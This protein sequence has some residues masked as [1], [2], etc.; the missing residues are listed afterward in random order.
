MTLH[1]ILFFV[2]LFFVDIAA[3][4]QL[5]KGTLEN[6][7]SMNSPFNLREKQKVSRVALFSNHYG[8]LL[9]PRFEKSLNLQVSFLVGLLGV[10]TW[11]HQNS[12]YFHEVLQHIKTFI[13]T[14]FR[15]QRVLRFAIEDTWISRLLSDAAFSWR[16]GKLLCGLK[17]LLIF[18]D[19]VI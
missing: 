14:N 3:K 6:T 19:A 18:W 4:R 2:L 8:L 11:R 10:F 12:I 5:L 9:R 1:F 16:P 7:V 15:F 17:T 13:Y